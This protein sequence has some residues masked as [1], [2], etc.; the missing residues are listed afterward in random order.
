M[1]DV[2][3]LLGFR[4]IIDALP[5]LAPHELRMSPSAIPSGRTDK[6]N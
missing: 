2:F 6:S 3:R 5:E 4:T 1:V